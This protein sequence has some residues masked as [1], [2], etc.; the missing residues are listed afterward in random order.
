MKRR[1]FVIRVGSVLLVIP[2]AG[3][4][5]SC[6]DDDN[7]QNPNPNPNPNPTFTGLRFT[8]SVRDGHN[9]TIDITFDMLMNA[10]AMGATLTSS[11][12]ANH[13]HQVFLTMADLQSI[14][15]NGTI[16]KDTSLAASHLHTFTFT[17]S[18]GQQF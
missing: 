4:L 13:V 3:V 2:A 11:N 5:A 7:N 15:A 16:V 8:S 12:V 1:D 18:G 10:P 14:N 17:K 9:H 6:G